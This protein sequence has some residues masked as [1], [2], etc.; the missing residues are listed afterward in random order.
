MIIPLCVLLDLGQERV[1]TSAYSN[2]DLPA[3]SCLAARGRRLPPKL[4]AK[5]ARE[6][7]SAQVLEVNRGTHFEGH[8]SA[9]YRY[10]KIGRWQ[11]QE[12]GEK[13]G[14]RSREE[15]GRALVDFVAVSCS[16]GQLSNPVVSI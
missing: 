3:L 6:L 9:A 14:K 7:P 16:I 8:L 11:R 13:K 12:G 5:K 4:R 2:K 15:G 1:G 10:R